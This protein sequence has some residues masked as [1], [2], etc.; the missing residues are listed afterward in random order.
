M[1]GGRGFAARKL[2]GKDVARGGGCDKENGF[3]E[4]TDPKLDRNGLLVT[5]VS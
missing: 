3:G 4:I 5:F 1:L 2:S